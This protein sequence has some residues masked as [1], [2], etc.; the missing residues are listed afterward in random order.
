MSFR[1]IY[2]SKENPA[3]G[4]ERETRTAGLPGAC[5]GVEALDRVESALAV[6]A[7]TDV[8]VA[9]GLPRPR[10]RPRCSQRRFAPFSH[11]CCTVPN[12]TAPYYAV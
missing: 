11:E 9:H 7:A 10:A 2:P 1:E 5:P 3:L 12:H 8:D 4:S 6:P